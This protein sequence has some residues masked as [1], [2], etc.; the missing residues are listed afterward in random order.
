MN[1]AAPDKDAI[2]TLPA[3]SVPRIR[4]VRQEDK[5]TV[6]A[7]CEH[8]FECGDYIK[9]VFDEWLSGEGD[10]L[11][12]ELDGRAVGIVHVAYLGRGDQAWFEGMRVDPAYRVRGVARALARAE[13]EA[14]RRRD[15]RVAR[16]MVFGNNAGGH[17]VSRIAGLQPLARQAHL[18]WRPQAGASDLASA[19]A[20]RLVVVQNDASDVARAD[21]LM[22][23]AAC[24]RGPDGTPG[25]LCDWGWEDV[26]PDSLARLAGRGHLLTTDA[27]DALA[28]FDVWHQEVEVFLNAGDAAAAAR[29]GAAAM[30]FAVDR[31]YTELAVIVPDDAAYR[32][33]LQGVGF[34]PPGVPSG[35]PGTYVVYEMMLERGA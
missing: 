17:A 34:E 4:P 11:A 21:E 26:A 14:A 8:T 24:N 7:F 32:D 3:P 31:S 33:A 5:S 12:A 19:G 20:P 27:W 35:H 25:L 18:L 15:C 28:A 13:V 29:L 16:C 2:P 10:F 9:Y 22:R 30:R 23:R 1:E 6:L